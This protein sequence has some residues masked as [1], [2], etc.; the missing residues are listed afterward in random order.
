M[1]HLLEK[2]YVN[3]TD[4]VRTRNATDHRSIYFVWE[5]SIHAMCADEKAQHLFD[6]IG[7]NV[8]RCL[9]K[10]DNSWDFLSRELNLYLS[11]DTGELIHHWYNPWTQETLPVVHVANRY[12]SG[13]FKNQFPAYYYNGT[14]NFKFDLFP[15]YPNP[16]AEYAE[17]SP[18]PTYQA[19]ELFELRVPWHE[20]TDKTRS[21]VSQLELSWKR[22]GPWLPWMKMGQRTGKLYYS[23]IGTRMEHFEQ[24]PRLLQQEIEQQ[25]PI[26]RDAPQQR[27]NRSDVTSWSYFRDYFQDYQQGRRFPRPEYE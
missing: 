18:E 22:I 23:A 2:N 10:E 4:W 21:S 25:V 26:Y 6:C 16:L 5:G 7:L 1:S 8:S 15:T 20:A 12:V 11:P 3:T 14:L 24:L 13:T 19:A 27:E 9:Q 17:Y